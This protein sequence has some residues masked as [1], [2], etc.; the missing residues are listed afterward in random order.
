[1]FSCDRVQTLKPW[2]DSYIKF[3]YFMK[4]LYCLISTILCYFMIS[5]SRIDYLHSMAEQTIKSVQH[6]QQYLV[7]TYANSIVFFC[8]I[9][10]IQILCSYNI[11][12]WNFLIWY[13]YIMPFLFTI[14]CQE[15]FPNALKHFFNQFKRD[16][17][18]IPDLLQIAVILSL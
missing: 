18:I 1:M 14:L 15:I 17:I 2:K 8:F 3:S 7:L 9:R 13:S 4:I 16:I 6:T 12:F 10:S 11:K 5:V